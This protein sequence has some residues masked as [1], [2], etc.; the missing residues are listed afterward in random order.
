MGI[1]KN[2]RVESDNFIWVYALESSSKVKVSQD[3]YLAK[4]FLIGPN[5]VWSENQYQVRPGESDCLWRRRRMMDLWRWRG[6][7]P[8][9]RAYPNEGDLVM[10]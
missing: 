2:H 1:K 9:G 4:I 5:G 7:N 3:I 8:A 6:V 10:K